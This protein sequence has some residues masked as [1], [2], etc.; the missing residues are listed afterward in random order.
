[1]LNTLNIRRFLVLCCLFVVSPW[2]SA[3]ESSQEPPIQQLTVGQTHIIPAKSLKRIAV[4]NGEILQVE[5][6]EKV[7]EV[8]VIAKEPGISDVV[9]WDKRGNKQRYLINVKGYVDGP[10]KNVIDAL[11]A[12]IDG[13]NIREIDNNF[14]IE[15]TVGTVRQHERVQAIAEKY[16]NIHS[17]V[18]PPEFEHKQTVL[19]HA[20]FLEVSRNAMQEIGI[21]WGDAINGPVF[22]FIDDVSVN[23]YFRGAGLPD[24]AILNPALSDLPNSIQGSQSYFGLSTSLTSAINLMKT[25]GDAKLLAEPTLSSISGGSADFL[26]GGE[27]PIPVTGNDGEITVIFKEFGVSLEIQP[28]VDKSGYIQTE[29][30]I[31][32]SAIDNSVSVRGI[33]G[34]TTRKAS[35]EMHAESGQTIVLAGLFSQEGSK[36]VDKL[37]GLGDL[38]IIG[39][40]FKSRSFRNN[41][42]ELI[43]LVT[44]RV[45]DNKAEAEQGMKLFKRLQQ[46]SDEALKFSIMD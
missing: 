11:F 17:L 6:L 8:L 45:V 31:E 2:L 34:F 44:P 26:A 9:I 5:A 25:N 21:N 16:S 46:E 39:E 41:E 3:A 15:G 33:P 19:I 38:P 18:F 20:Q 28:L 32:V 37:P 1:M 36:T 10:T 14:V 35:T 29:V 12:D 27:V 24:G 23:D 42:S 4:G 43:V 30:E 13:I 22:S 7:G 40:L